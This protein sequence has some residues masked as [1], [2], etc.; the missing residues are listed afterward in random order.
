MIIDK[1]T[2]FSDSQAVTVTAVSTDTVDLKT[3]VNDLG[4][5]NQLWL[6]VLCKET[7][8]AAGAATVDFAYV[9]DDNAALASPAVLRATGAIGKA[10]LT[11]GTVVALWQVPRNTQRYV[12]MQ[13]TVATGPL[14][15]GKFSAFFTR[16]PDQWKALPDAVERF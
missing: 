8:T 1:E 9:D 16:N 11:A 7:V 4:V 3:D 14:T 10:S 12:G 6:V 2:Q 5:G 15:A 13:Y